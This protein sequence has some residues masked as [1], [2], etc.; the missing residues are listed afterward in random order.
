MARKLSE[1]TKQ[2]RAT[3]RAMDRY[4]KL[5]NKVADV[6]ATLRIVEQEAF[7]A[8][9]AAGGRRVLEHEFL[10]G[11]SGDLQPEPKPR[12]RVRWLT[13]EEAAQELWARDKVQ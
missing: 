3:N 12:R 6:R 1:L 11:I 8:F 2:V 10:A 4:G 7:Q 5:A 13:Q 9:E